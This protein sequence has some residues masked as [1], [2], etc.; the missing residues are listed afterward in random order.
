[1]RKIRENIL[2]FYNKHMP[3]YMVA[4]FISITF[5]IIAFL[6]MRFVEKESKPLKY[7]LR[8]T[9]FVYFSVFV[10]HFIM[11]QISPATVNAKIAVFTDD[12]GF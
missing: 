9:I 10:A 5:F 6:E 12:P 8:D 4:A 7:L 3:Q 1:M 11:D 2:H